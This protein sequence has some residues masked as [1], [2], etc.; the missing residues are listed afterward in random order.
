MIL[1]DPKPSAGPGRLR[2]L[3]AICFAIFSTEVLLPYCS[4]VHGILTEN[5]NKS[6]Y[7]TF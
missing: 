1:I 2:Y 3:I 7:D 5:F 6:F 4:P